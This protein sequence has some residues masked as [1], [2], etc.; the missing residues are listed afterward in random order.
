MHETP[1]QGKVCILFIVQINSRTT[2]C[3]GKGQYTKS[4]GS[5]LPP[6]YKHQPEKIY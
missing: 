6:A 3:T 4:G 5:K 1:M 2:N